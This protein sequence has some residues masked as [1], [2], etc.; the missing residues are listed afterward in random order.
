MNRVE[1]PALGES[2]TRKRVMN[3]NMCV[4]LIEFM[5]NGIQSVER[6]FNNY[7]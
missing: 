2:G 4:A 5:P 7:I 1:V 3:D 6:R